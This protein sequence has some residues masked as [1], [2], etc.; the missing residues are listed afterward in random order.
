MKEPTDS[1]AY[2][3]VAWSF[4]HWP[5]YTVTMQENLIHHFPLNFLGDQLMWTLAL[6]SPLYLLPSPPVMF[7]ITQVL[8]ICTGAILLYRI[9][10][11]RLSD[12]LLALLIATCYLFNPAT[13]LSF[14]DF[15]FRAE[16]LFIPLT[17]AIFLFVEKGRPLCAGLALTAFLLTK[18][19]AIP[20]A[21]LLGLYF[22]VFH[23]EQ[24]RF[25]LFCILAAAAYYVI[26]VDFVMSHLQE[27]P[28]AHF[29][30]FARFGN[31]PGAALMNMAAHPGQIVAMISAAKLNYFIRI[32]FPAGFLALLS[33]SFW[34]CSSELLINAVLPEYHS[35]FCG[36]HWSLVVPFIFLGMVATMHWILKKSGSPPYL[37]YLFASILVFQL[38]LNISDIG[39]KILNDPENFY[40]REK[41]IDTQKLTEHLS[42]IDPSASVMASSQ[43]LWFF[44]DRRHIYN[45]RVKFHDEVDYIA[46][47]WPMNISDYGNIDKFLLEELQRDPA[48][49]KLNQFVVT[50]RDPNLVLLKH[51]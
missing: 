48:E 39:G 38:V 49:S 28:T 31:T 51:K 19:N 29:K 50:V 3:Q 12:P 6:F 25:G 9:T 5:P 44:S 32:V 4:L 26:G 18:H 24:R 33:P 10:S 16:T 2:M 1:A 36:W 34:I 41:N 30:H 45:A 17:F 42:S 27:N 11:R 47:L 40:F 14:A 8:I 37:K 21:V 35:I 46:I 15:G 22:M 20:V 7:L 13:F 23:R 43:L